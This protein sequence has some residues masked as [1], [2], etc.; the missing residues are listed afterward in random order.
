[1]DDL[2]FNQPVGYALAK[3]ER[4]IEQAFDLMC[5]EGIWL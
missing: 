5:G 2:A 1:V 4:K 3:I